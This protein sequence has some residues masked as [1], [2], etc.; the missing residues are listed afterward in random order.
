MTSPPTFFPTRVSSVPPTEPPIVR[1][2]MNA[3]GGVYCPVAPVPGPTLREKFAKIRAAIVGNPARYD[4]V[5]H[6]QCCASREIDN[7]QREP[8]PEYATPAPGSFRYNV[9][10]IVT[11]TGPDF[12]DQGVPHGYEGIVQVQSGSC[13]DGVPLYVVAFKNGQVYAYR[14]D[15]LKPAAPGCPAGMHRGEC[16]PDVPAGTFTVGM[17]VRV[18][19][20]PY[21]EV[22]V[23]R[24]HHSGEVIGVTRDDGRTTSYFARVLQPLAVDLDAELAAVAP[25]WVW[26]EVS[27]TVG[28]AHARWFANQHN[29]SGAVF[30]EFDK[31]IKE[32]EDRAPPPAIAD[33]VTRR[34]ADEVRERAA[35]KLACAGP[36]AGSIHNHPGGIDSPCNCGR[37][38]RGGVRA[39]VEPPVRDWDAELR[40]IA[41]RMKWREDSEVSVFSRW[42]VGDGEFAV[43]WEHGAPCAAYPR[44]QPACAVPLSGGKHPNFDEI[45]R[46]VAERN[47]VVLAVE[48]E[49][50]PDGA[51]PCCHPEACTGDA[52][53][54][55]GCGE[56]HFFGGGHENPCTCG[57]HKSLAAE[58]AMHRESAA[59]GIARA[60]A[61]RRALGPLLDWRTESDDR[62]IASR[63]LRKPPCAHLR[64]DENAYARQ[65]CDCK[66]VLR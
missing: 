52:H 40:A 61:G 14:E 21:G 3:H 30:W 26:C 62:G 43:L 25:E 51:C 1:P 13:T 39:P 59:A 46:L 5:P 45:A 7:G 6:R 11:T 42:W 10:A 20:H 66:E 12:Y 55:P 60:A 16:V 28:R 18:L 4:V 37:F 38:I 8:E 64:W 23:R 27:Q 63:T 17:R 35:A 65:C 15:C 58:E 56:S 41:P 57:L 9:S 50:L 31:G 36:C 53:D 49:A 33:L 34:N 29:G 44:G 32:V 24:I 19:V 48:P 47:G 2:M 54:N 22:T